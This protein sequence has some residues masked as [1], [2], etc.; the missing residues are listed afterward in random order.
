MKTVF[1][2]LPEKHDYLSKIVEDNYELQTNET[3][4]EPVGAD[5]TGIKLPVTF[6]GTKWIE[7]TDEEHKSYIESQI[8]GPSVMDKAVAALTLQIA[9]NKAD[10]DA[11]N[12]QLLLATASQTAKETN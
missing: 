3:F 12:A 11:V 2:Y 10:Q 8:N 7:A 4:V 6:D 1:T 9:Q 5:K